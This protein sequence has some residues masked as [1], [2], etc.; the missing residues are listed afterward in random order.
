MMLEPAPAL[1]AQ[2]NFTPA[3]LR[4]RLVLGT[5]QHHCRPAGATADVDDGTAGNRWRPCFVLEGGH[6][7]AGEPSVR[8]TIASPRR[9]LTV[10]HDASTSIT[11]PI[12]WIRA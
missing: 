4:A 8:A 11:Q 2:D 12:G 3:V 1:T 5:P 9:S 6:R 7:A 10:V